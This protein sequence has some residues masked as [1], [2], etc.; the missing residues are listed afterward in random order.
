ML[1]VNPTYI[2]TDS[3]ATYVGLTSW[4]AVWRHQGWAIHGRPIWGRPHTKALA[5]GHVDAHT[6]RQNKATLHN[7]VADVACRETHCGPA[8]AQWA[9][10]QSGHGGSQVTQEW[11]RAP[12]IP[13]TRD[14]TRTAVDHCPRCAELKGQP[15]QQ[16]ADRQI[17]RAECPG[18]IWQCNYIGPLPTEKRQRYLLTVVDTHTGLGYL[19]MLG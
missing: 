12:G 15:L 2:Y 13:L 7:A 3:W 17:K 16:V 14:E 6:K 19:K 1:K 18:Q 9:H 5:I 11:E 4:M 8:L 10:D